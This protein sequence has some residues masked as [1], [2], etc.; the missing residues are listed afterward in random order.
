MAS[1]GSTT[2]D[3][4]DITQAKW[5]KIQQLGMKDASTWYLAN[6]GA[7][8]SSYFI[9]FLMLILQLSSAAGDVANSSIPNNLAPGNYVIRHEI[10]ALHLAMTVGG[11][12]F[13]PS[14]SQ[15]RVGGDQTG[16]PQSS[17]LVSLPGAYSDTDPGIYAPDVYNPGFVYTFPGPPIASFISTNDENGPTSGNTTTPSTTTPTTSNPSASASASSRTC[18]I[19]K[20]STAQDNQFVLNARH[21][22]RKLGFS[23]RH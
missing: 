1:C 21:I 22:L 18:R 14:C 16:A 4:F 12:E 23:T 17:D 11:A 6:L 3:K 8:T 7:F 13:Y 9:L 5:F 15:L 2:C 20:S 19:V 10:I